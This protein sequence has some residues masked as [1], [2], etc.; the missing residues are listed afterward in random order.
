MLSFVAVAKGIE[1]S[2]LATK[3]YVYGVFP[4]FFIFYFIFFSIMKFMS[5]KR[6]MAT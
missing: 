6:T 4:S 5:Q 3:C 1:E 2:Y